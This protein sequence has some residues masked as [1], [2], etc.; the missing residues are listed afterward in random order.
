MKYIFLIVA[1]IL[2]GCSKSTT[3][4]PINNIPAELIGKWKITESYY[5]SGTDGYWKSYNSKKIVDLWL[6]PDGTYE[7]GSET[8][9]ENCT[10][11]ISNEKIYFLPNGVDS[12]AEIKF[13]NHT[14]LT[15]WW[16]DFEGAGFK[17]KKVA[18]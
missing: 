11:I 1:L 9:C 3:E 7:D 8:A 13:L 16:N 5:T 12:P 2:L 14:D 6:K 17:Y 10:F 15:L 18:E 4:E